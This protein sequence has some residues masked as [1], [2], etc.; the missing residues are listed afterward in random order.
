VQ[1]SQ[2][3]PQDVAGMAWL[4]D[5]LVVGLANGQAVALDAK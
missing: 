1:T 4:G 2:L 3:L 5:K